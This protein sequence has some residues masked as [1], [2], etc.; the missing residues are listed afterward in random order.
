M[1]KQ[2]PHPQHFYYAAIRAVLVSRSRFLSM[3][4]G[5]LEPTTHSFLRTFTW[6]WVKYGFRFVRTRY[7]LFGWKPAFL[8]RTCIYIYIYIYTYPYVFT[9]FLCL[10]WIRN[11]EPSEISSEAIQAMI[12][13]SVEYG[14]CNKTHVLIHGSEMTIIDGEMMWNAGSLKNNPWKQKRT[15]GF[16]LASYMFMGLMAYECSGLLPKHPKP[17]KTTNSWDDDGVPY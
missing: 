3:A 5:K 1:H 16:P 13:L 9:V 12:L 8:E 17:Q 11:R 6:L 7:R 4:H 10:L 14:V 15:P 2:I